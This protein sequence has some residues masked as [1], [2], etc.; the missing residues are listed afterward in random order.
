MSCPHAYSDG[1]YVLGALNPAERTTYEAHLAGCA[2]C[3]A[4][5]ARLTPLPGLLG[6]VDPDV[7]EPAPETPRVSKLLAAVAQ[8]RRRQVRVRRWQLA[9]AVLASAVLAM[10]ATGLVYTLNQEDPAD[11]PVAV[12]P[13]LTAMRP[14]EDWV[15][16]TA[17]VSVT[18]VVGGTEVHMECQYPAD[19]DGRAHLYWL[20]AVGD[21]G[22]TE[23]L[24]SW[25]AGPGED[26]SLT[27]LTR[28]TDDLA[29]LELRGEGETTLLI[30]P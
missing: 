3:S 16:I 9:G 10:V 26:A 23:S 17:Q 22:S 27:S 8:V 1:A 21:D 12:E 14:V 11:P 13:P 20:V 24:G 4:A 29:R 5:V 30:Y 25:S 19:V 2:T 7:L 28:Y 6:R 15:P 18:P